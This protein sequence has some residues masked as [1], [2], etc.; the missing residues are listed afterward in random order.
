MFRHYKISYVCL[1][2]SA[3]T[4][5]T[6]LASQS[7]RLNNAFFYYLRARLFP[8]SFSLFLKK[9]GRAFLFL[10]FVLFLWAFFNTCT[11]CGRRAST[12]WRA[13]HSAI[14]SAQSSEQS[15]CRSERDNASKKTR[16]GESSHVFEH[17]CYTARCVLKT[18]K[19]KSARPMKT[20]NH[21]R[22]GL[23]RMNMYFVHA[24]GVRLVVLEHGA[25]RIL[26]VV[27]LRLKSWTY[28]SASSAFCYVL[29][30]ERA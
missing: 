5:G 16:V 7:S 15:T 10:F 18:K 27:S 8:V 14:S 20:Y 28:L 30:C 11:S 3:G 26:Q 13:Q 25:L 23:H 6:S 17:F 4:I 22:N 9:I 2:F 1:L 12:V 19:S 24:C 29:A 21:S